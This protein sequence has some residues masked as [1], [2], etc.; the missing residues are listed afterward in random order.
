[1]I[2][3]E[4]VLLQMISPNRFQ[5]VPPT[6]PT[7]IAEIH[8]VASIMPTVAL[9]TRLNAGVAIRSASRTCLHR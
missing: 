4:V 1:M 5:V 7:K 9:N 8:V 6:T 2:N 3:E